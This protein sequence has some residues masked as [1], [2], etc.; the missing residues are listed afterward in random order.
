MVMNVLAIAVLCLTATALCKI[1]DKYNKE[2][3][4]FISLTVCII[5]LVSVIVYISPVL[6]M[7]KDMFTGAGINPDNIEILVKA[8]GICYLTQLAQDICKDNDQEAMATQAELVGKISLILLALPML[9]T[10]VSIVN[11]LISL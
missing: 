11:E 1:M 4:F 6:E 9:K 5:L 2:Y 3:S 8:L 7:A 10:L